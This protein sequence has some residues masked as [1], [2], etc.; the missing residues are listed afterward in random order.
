MPSEKVSKKTTAAA[1]AVAS[2][3][4]V[5]EKK[6]VA[7]APDA[8]VAPASPAAK[9]KN[10]QRLKREQVEKAVAA[11]QAFLAKKSS[12]PTPSSSGKKASLLDSDEDEAFLVQL[13]LKKV[14][15]DRNTMPIPLRVPHSVYGRGGRTMCLIVRDGD[16]G[17]NARKALEA[18]PVEGLKKIFSYSELKQQFS[19]YKDKRR[20]MKMFDLF[21]ADKAVVPLLPRLLG[22]SFFEAKR[23]PVGLRIDRFETRPEKIVVSAR[24]ATY[25]FLTTGSCLAIK[26]GD[27]SFS[28]DQLVD[29]IMA[30]TA[31][32]IEH[33]S[34][35]WKN[36]RNV[37]IKSKTSLALPV[38]LEINQ[39]AKALPEVDSEDEEEDVSDVESESEEEEV[40]APA[41]PAKKAAKKEVEEVEM[42]PAAAVAKAAKKSAATPAPAPAPAATPSKVK[43]VVSDKLAEK[44][45]AATPAKKTKK[46][47]K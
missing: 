13:T 31:G 20:L 5:A 19:A 44:P 42:K 47:D 23:Q 39:L 6:V 10:Q 11:L 4:V 28:R 2:K 26:V 16:V 30:A 25:F 22:K 41:K 14:P 17:V 45:A 3:K 46:A 43:K 40:K 8:S 18:T 21:L 38:Y 34:G 1:P 7:P 29:N 9:D 37:M 27:A 12:D 33:I 32:A 24:D 15:A 35:G 36:I